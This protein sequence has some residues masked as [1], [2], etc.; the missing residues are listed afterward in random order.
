[1]IQDV[2]SAFSPDQLLLNFSS[3]AQLLH[4]CSA[5]D[6]SPAYA[7][8]LSQRPTILFLHVCIRCFSPADGILISRLR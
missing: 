7:A 4:G 8:P 3:S 6:V 2:N 1:M 5:A